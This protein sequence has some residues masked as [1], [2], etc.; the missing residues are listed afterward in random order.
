LYSIPPSP[1]LGGK[2]SSKMKNT[3]VLLFIPL[4]IDELLKHR[5][6]IHA[7]YTITPFKRST[8]KSRSKSSS[9]ENKEDGQT[10]EKR[11]TRDRPK[12]KKWYNLHLRVDKRKAC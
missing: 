10:R 2:N 1:P 11:S 4:Q 6:E 3:E 12:K 7:S 9:K 5:N 8:S